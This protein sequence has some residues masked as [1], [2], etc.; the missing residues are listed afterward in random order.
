M[1]RNASD[2]D[3]KLESQLSFHSTQ[4]LQLPPRKSAAAQPL[5]KLCI[6]NPNKKHPKLPRGKPILPPMHEKIQELQKQQVVTSQTKKRQRYHTPAAAA[7]TKSITTAS[8]GKQASARKNCANQRHSSAA[9]KFT[10]PPLPLVQF[11]ASKRTTPAKTFQSKLNDTQSSSSSDDSDDEVQLIASVAKRAIKPAGKSLS[12]GKHANT[13]KRPLQIDSSSSSDSEL[14][15]PYEQDL[16][17]SY[18]VDLNESSNEPLRPGDVIQYCSPMYVA[19]RPE[20]RCVAQVWNTD[21]KRQFPLVLSNGEFLPSDHQVKRIKELLKGELVQHPGM[22]RPIQNFRMKKA[23]MNEQVSGN[24][25]AFE[26]QLN[27]LQKM[28]AQGTKLIDDRMA[29]KTKTQMMESLEDESTTDADKKQHEPACNGRT[30]PQSPSSSSTSSSSSDDS[31]LLP[32]PRR[33]LNS[34]GSSISPMEILKKTAISCRVDVLASGKND[35]FLSSDSEVDDDGGQKASL[36]RIDPLSTEKHTMARESEPQYTEELLEARSQ[37]NLQTFTL[38]GNQYKSTAQSSTGWLTTKRRPAE[39]T[40]FEPAAS[41]N[42][43]STLLGNVSAHDDAVEGLLGFR[44]GGT[45]Y[46]SGA[47]ER[48]PKG[49]AE[50]PPI[51]DNVET[52]PVSHLKVTRA[53]DSNDVRIASA[54]GRH[55]SASR[56]TGMYADLPSSD[57]DDD[58]Y[59]LAPSGIDVASKVVHPTRQSTIPP[60]A[61]S[62]T[63][64]GS[65]LSVGSPLRKRSI[66]SSPYNMSQGTGTSQQTPNGVRGNAKNSRDAQERKRDYVSIIYDVRLSSSDESDGDR[67]NKTRKRRKAAA[68]VTRHPS[69]FRPTG[70]DIA[71]PCPSSSDEESPRKVRSNQ[72]TRL[73]ATETGSLSSIQNSTQSSPDTKQRKQRT[74]DEKYA[75]GRAN[76]VAQFSQ[77][78]FTQAPVGGRLTFVTTSRST[79]NSY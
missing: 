1:P 16:G 54:I 26:K 13:S 78:R 19:G 3:E 58:N 20:G 79:S 53:S 64:G 10:S 56:A 28:I 39:K 21:P 74:S 59:M 33:R 42:V 50:Q 49:K 18:C 72:A 70:L 12:N 11:T 7:A 43:I 63:Q 6:G 75:W 47:S 5:R 15:L 46:A 73:S 65:T 69:A 62:R 32:R 23:A 29:K 8:R 51:N 66:R 24:M 17:Q 9:K 68:K 76:N 4:S 31:P 61:P 48:L 55:E 52:L 37:S 60:L 25:A 40:S 38:T 22:F 44:K 30:S 27:D 34:N 67:R 2:D 57:S 36:P 77:H 45:A 14:E 41:V 71:S 35:D